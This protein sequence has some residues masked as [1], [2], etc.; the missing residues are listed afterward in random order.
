MQF[1]YHIRLIK[2]GNCI[3]N[4]IHFSLKRALYREMHRWPS[5]CGGNHLGSP[6]LRPA[7]DSLF[8]F[9]F[10]LLH[11]FSQAFVLFCHCCQ[12]VLI[13]LQRLM[14]KKIKNPHD[15]SLHP[16]RWHFQRRCRANSIAYNN[17]DLAFQLISLRLNGL[18]VSLHAAHLLLDSH[19]LLL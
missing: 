7:D 2:I 13:K 6:N 3:S 14:K 10:H 15:S 16:K 9:S 18:Q 12:L 1:S 4:P 11:L 5:N 17:L 19:H 8:G